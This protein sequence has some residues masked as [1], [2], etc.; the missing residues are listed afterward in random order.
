MTERPFL[1]DVS[2]LIWRVW[3][4]R[5]PTGIDRV[6]LAYIEHFGRRSRAVV[7]RGGM[8]RIL[9][10]R[11]SDALFALLLAGEGDFRPRFLQLA[12]QVL[13]SAPESAGKDR[14]IYINV[15]HTGLDR[16]DLPRWIARE[17][18]RAVF[19]IHD[20]IP[21]THPEFCR[22]GESEKHARRMDHALRSASGII[23]NSQATA[24]SLSGFAE[25]SRLPMPPHAVAWIAGHKLP[26][27]AGPKALGRPYFVSLGTI[28]GRKNHILL[29]Q[30][31]KGLIA[32]MGDRAPMLVIIG[33]RGWEAEHALATLDRAP[34]LRGHVLELNNASDAETAGYVEGA[35]ALLMPSYV[36]G[37]GMPVIE[38]LELG[39]PVI[40]SDIPVFREI[41]GDIPTYL[42]S[43]DG[44]GWERAI[45]DFLED[46]PERQRQLG[47]M[48]AYTP[49]SWEAHFERVE[50]WLETLAGRPVTAQAPASGAATGRRGENGYYQT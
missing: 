20:L 16:P 48:P 23:V 17:K 13:L 10:P 38:A 24:E 47:L 4:G 8:R 41:A 49:P 45:V 21:V 37:F 26:P 31:W 12:A 15:G 14:P 32:R 43:C 30:L 35:R 27:S 33:Q 25:Q 22:A 36:E 39:T 29:L 19:L 11:H 2:R 44:A 18:L 5:I 50:R 6:C 1:L 40:A 7:Q 9:S 46:C 42:D 3:T 34:T 28:E